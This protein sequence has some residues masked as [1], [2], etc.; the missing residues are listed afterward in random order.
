MSI[1]SLDDLFVHEL[2]HARAAEKY[3]LDAM[4]QM[5]A[6]ANGGLA[7]AIF[8]NALQSKARLSRLEDVFKLLALEPVPVSCTATE[9]LFTEADCLI[10]E[11]DD[12]DTRLAA[13]SAA[14]QNLSRS[15]LARYETLAAWAITLG[16]AREAN[17][18]LG[19]IDHGL[20]GSPTSSEPR[21]GG[22]G[23]PLTALLD[24]G[25]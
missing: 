14:L 2:R 25:K 16:K 18:L 6:L 20:A 21:S 10:R 24:K 8:R 15:L 19:A 7:E 5:A 12:R 22:M 9:A 23:D 11:V 17:L 3:S 1:R 13:A 4:A